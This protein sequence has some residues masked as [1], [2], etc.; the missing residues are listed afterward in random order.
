MDGEKL[1]G[2]S[3]TTR[4]SVAAMVI[5]MHALLLWIFENTTR[6]RMRS[7]NGPVTYLVLVPVAAKKP[8]VKAQPDDAFH[9]QSSDINIP[10]VSV[11]VSEL[12]S[13]TANTQANIDWEKEADRAAKNAAKQFGVK[14]LRSFGPPEDPCDKSNPLNEFKVQCQKAEPDLDWNPNTPRLGFGKKP[15]PNGH[16]FDHLK[17]LYLKKPVEDICS[18]TMANCDHSSSSSAH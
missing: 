5:A 13:D 1:L 10:D 16:L 15:P 14:K 3:I 12:S 6:G 18:K 17:P 4:V 7:T 9:F 8:F 11:D 2:S